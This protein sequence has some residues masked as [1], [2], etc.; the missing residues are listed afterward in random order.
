MC[1]GVVSAREPN[2]ASTVLVSISVNFT[3]G[4]ASHHQL[5]LAVLEKI[6]AIEITGTL[7][8]DDLDFAIAAQEAVVFNNG[9]RLYVPPVALIL[10]DLNRLASV[11]APNRRDVAETVVD[12]AIVD[13]RLLASNDH[14]DG[15]LF[16][17]REL[18]MVDLV[19]RGRTLD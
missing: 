16:E 12:D 3:V 13:G 15:S 14:L 1:D 5:T 18:A 6:V 8:A 17:M 11:S 9:S 2:A 4:S 19:P 10:A 7:V